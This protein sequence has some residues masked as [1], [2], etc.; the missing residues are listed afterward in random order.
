VKGNPAKG[1][2]YLVRGFKL[3]TQPGLRLFVLIPL[4]INIVIFSVLIGA[5]ISEFYGWIEA[6]MNW[7]P[8]FLSFIRWVLWPMALVLILTVIMYSFSVIANIIASPFN[9]LLAEK[10]EEMLTGSEVDGYETIG[11]AILAFPKSI[12]REVAKLAY[13]IPLALTVLVISFIPV[14][15]AVAPILWFLLG[16]WMMVIQYCDYPMDNNRRSFSAMKQAIAVDRLT[17]AGFGAGVMAGTMIPLINFIIMPAAVC[18][19]TVY[20]VEELKPLTPKPTRKGPPA[21]T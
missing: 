7:V 5:T 8:D 12:S 3:V 16:T 11:K 9:G 15:N 14:V 4:T 20:W 1:F 2:N 21:L 17:S 13:Y 6:I 19:A 10:V 18:G